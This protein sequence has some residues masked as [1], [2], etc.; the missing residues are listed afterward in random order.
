MMYGLIGEKITHSFSPEIHKELGNNDYILNPLLSTELAEFFD[1]KDFCGINVTIP[2][3]EAVI[4]YLDNI[5]KTAEEIGA[6]NTIV[7]GNNGA[8][9][10]YNTDYFGFCAMLSYHN[11][12]VKG[13]KCLVLGSGGASKTVTYALEKLGAREY[14]VISRQGE[15]NYDNLQRH[16]DAEI[17]INTTPLGMY[18]NNGVSAVDCSKFTGLCAAID[19][20]FNPQITEFLFS[21][22]SCGVKTVNGLYMLV[23]QAKR[24]AEL[25][26]GK[27]I[28]DSETE[29]IYKKI[30]SKVTNIVLIGMPSSGK[31]TIGTLVAQKSGRGFFDTDERICHNS[32]KKIP[33]I[34]KNEGES[35]FRKLESIAAQQIGNLSG[36]VI[37]TGGGI[38]TRAENYNPLRQNGLIFYLKR[39]L[40]EL[41]CDGRP[42][43]STKEKIVELFKVRSPLYES[44][45]DYTVTS[46]TIE[47][48]A[49]EIIK[50]FNKH[51]N[52]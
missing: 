50:I 12:S 10:G 23:A 43:S 37:A 27:D 22:L 26:F 30:Q 31:T 45:A 40:E 52:L 39:P 33:Y 24:A 47:E 7:K 38:V 46:T 48:T 6:V 14:I 5:D 25:F 19:L 9:T 28:P 18:P 51:F 49:D 32:S 21:A 11:I 8:L 42:L 41:I 15:N 4:K 36:V 35:E 44:F 3:K 16:Y 29:R 20:I 34:I 1:K 13:K 2:Y 17:I